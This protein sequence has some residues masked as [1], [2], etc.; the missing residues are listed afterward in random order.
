MKFNS[1]RDHKERAAPRSEVKWWQIAEHIQC[2]LVRPHMATPGY[3]S[4]Q[5]SSLLNYRWPYSH[6]TFTA[7]TTTVTAVTTTTATT[8]TSSHLG[9]TT[10]NSTNIVNI[11]LTSVEEDQVTLFD[12]LQQ[13]SFIFATTD[14]MLYK[15]CSY[16]YTSTTLTT[17]TTSNTTNIANIS[18]KDL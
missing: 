10:T 18:D 13:F 9:A 1:V 6:H 4:H 14:I 16:I 7:A 3:F 2:K 11:I 17:T 12:F 5:L 8:T 15:H